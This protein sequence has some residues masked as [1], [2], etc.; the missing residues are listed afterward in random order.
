MT[1]GHSATT[2]RSVVVQGFT[3]SVLDP[4]EPMLGPLENG[5]TII[6]NTA[7]GCWGPMITPRLRGGHEVTQP[8]FVA[9]AEPGDAVAIRIRD[10][11]VTSLATASGHDSSPAGFCLGDP[12]VAARCPVCDEIWPETH[13]EGIGQDAV[14]CDRCGNAVKPFEIVHGYTVVFDHAHGVGL[15]MPRSAADKIAHE[16]KHYAALPDHSVQHSILTFAPADMAGVPVR[17]RPFLG[18]LGTT[19]SMALPDSHNAGDFGAFLVGAPHPYAVTAEQLAAHKTD[20]HMDIDAVRAGAILVAPVKVKGAGVYMGDMHA[21]QGDGEIA[22]HT[23]DVAGSVTLQVEVVKNYRIDGPVLFPLLED[24]PPL[25]R[26]LSPA[27]KAAAQKL[28]S[29]WGV[30]AIEELAPISVIG[31]AANMNAAIDNGLQRAAD[32]LG[33]T[34]PEIR[35]RATV[36][37]AIEIGRAPGVIQVTFLAPLSRLDAAGLG[38]Y[39]REQYGL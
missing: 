3:N 8:V 29:Q 17:L 31:T 37:G 24:L 16:A 19:P 1:D 11:T 4:K 23:M 26:P 27:E 22:G 9:G 39:A 10:I 28:A 13:V 18:Q 30:S 12:Y 2:Q 20:G 32:L 33:L 25:A 14:R 35:N 6:A 36:N 7:P 15:T 21:A 34:V 5:G 38:D